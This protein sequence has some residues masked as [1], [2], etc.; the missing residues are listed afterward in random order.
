[1][2]RSFPKPIRRLSER[3]QVRAKKALAWQVCCHQV[4]VR[5]KWRCR[6]CHRRVVST[7]TLCAERL[8]HHHLVPRSRAPERMFDVTN[9]VSLCCSCHTKITHHEL[10]VVGSLNAEGPLTFRSTT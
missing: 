6:A 5:D 3:Q 10:E 9:V 8:E 1:M 2:H 7:I 4:D